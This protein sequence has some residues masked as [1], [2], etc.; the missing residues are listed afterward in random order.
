MEKPGMNILMIAP[1]SIGVVNGGV[2]IQS[3]KTAQHLKKFGVGVDLFNP[4]NETDV[5]RYD[6]VHLFLASNETLTIA[7]RLKEL[8]CKMVVSPVFFTRR[9]AAVIRQSIKIE[10]VAGKLVKGIFSDYSIKASV[11][12]AAKL[13]LPNTASEAG[14]IRDG[15]G[16]PDEHIAVIPNGVD[17]SFA[18]ATPDRFRSKH[19]VQN[20]TL[21][22]GDA[23]ARRKNVLHLLQQHT[24]NDNPLVIIGKFDQS[25]YSV[26]CINIINSRENIHY[27]GP[28]NHDDPMLASAY[29]AADVFALPSQFETPGIAA[30]EAGLAGC[31]L[32]ITK[33]G[34][35]QEV[36]GNFAEYIDPEN[37]RSIMQAIRRAHELPKDDSLKSIILEN[38]TWETVAQQTL[39]AYESLTG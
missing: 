30:L 32:A 38:Y 15:F 8:D 34:G 6:L 25:D 1:L 27:L 28:L 3:T 24:P 17:S 12:K 9:S 7:S 35:T 26:N 19:D 37:K 2:R 36:F 13:V 33:V 29:A 4:W 23:S 16:I 39:T 10:T 11:C 22:V 21:F 31:R 18:D 5:T 14:L 20:F